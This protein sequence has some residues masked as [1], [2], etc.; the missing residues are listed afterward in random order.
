MSA[1]VTVLQAH[2][3]QAYAAGT[4]AYQRAETVEQTPRWRTFEYEDERARAW[5]VWQ[6]TRPNAGYVAHRLAQALG[7]EDPARQLRGQAVYAAQISRNASVEGPA[8]S[9]SLL[10]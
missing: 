2:A 8:G 10:V 4:R 3:V 5:R 6:A 1:L 9:V 7:G